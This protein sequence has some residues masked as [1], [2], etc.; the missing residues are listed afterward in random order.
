MLSVTVPTL[1]VF[2]ALIVP[3][4]F[5]LTAVLVWPG[6]YAGDRLYR[7][8]DES[9]RSG[10]QADVRRYDRVLESYG[11]K[12]VA[13]E[14]RFWAPSWLIATTT[15]SASEPRDFDAL[16]R[17]LASILWCSSLTMLT[18]VVGMGAKTLVRN[19]TL[20]LTPRKLA[21]S[22]LDCLAWRLAGHEAALEKLGV[23]NVS[24]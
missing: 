4:G 8:R 19:P 22:T 3:L 24:I 9:W 21:D 17:Q 13:R 7:L 2:L 5:T 10:E 15:R 18:F 16:H 14:D 23:S 20:V 11:Y 1:V 12:R 6:E